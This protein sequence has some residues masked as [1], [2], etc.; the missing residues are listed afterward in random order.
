MADSFS[1]A[2]CTYN[3]ARFVGEQLES[4]AA[5]SRPPAELVVCDDGSADGTVGVVE[6]FAAS[7]PFPVRLFVNG[8]NL[9]STKNF[10]RAVSLCAGD[11][12]ALSD[13]DDVWLPEKLELMGE[14]FERS[15][16]VGL[17]FTDAEV[18]DEQLRPLGYNSWQSTGEAEFG[19]A[20]RRLFERGRALDVLLRGN[21]VTGAAMAFRAK[22]K[23][24]ALPIPEG[25]GL[26]HDGWIA[27]VVASVAR[28]DFVARPLI[29]YRQHPRQQL[30]AHRGD[31]GGEGVVAAGLSAAGR[32]NPYAAELRKLGALID[33][34]AAAGGEYDAGPAL[35][36]LARRAAHLRARAALPAG[37]LRRLPPVL[38]ELLSLRYHAHSNGLRSAAKDLL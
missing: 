1:V 19:P 32:A 13:Q 30:G 18:V 22:Y 16:G 23:G 31:E 36:T 3:G 4:I 12:V 35:N 14:R 21:V 26:I 34:L 11:L 28:A 8:K 24:L 27:L 29:K 17:V 5:Q 20:K 25:L 6:R 9:G 2:M 38:R 37:R 33:R 10:E 7:A 15:A